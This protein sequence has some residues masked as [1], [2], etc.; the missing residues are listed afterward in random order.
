M[1]GI[2]SAMKFDFQHSWLVLACDLPFVTTQT[3]KYL[4]EHRD[5]QKTATVYQS[6]HDQLPEPLCAIYE[7]HA[8]KNMVAYFQTG[9]TC[10]RKFL[11]HADK[12]MLI[13]PDPHAL[14]NVND[15][16]EYEDAMRQLTQGK[17]AKRG[18]PRIPRH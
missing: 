14:D 7:A 5:I 16:T 3:L 1:G 9:K 15:P 8:Y 2:L 10:P 18:K 17:P 6:H 13:L 11:I 4:I 12:K